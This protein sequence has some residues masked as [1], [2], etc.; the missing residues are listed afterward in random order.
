MTLQGSEGFL[1]A[2]YH[3][4]GIAMVFRV[5]PKKAI[6]PLAIAL[7]ECHSLLSSEVPACR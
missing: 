7:L 5:A 4:E 3:A 6:T 1:V 2:K